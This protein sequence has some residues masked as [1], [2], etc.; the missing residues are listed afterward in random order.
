MKTVVNLETK[1]VRIIIAKFFGIPVESV[2]PN[3]YSFS[4]EGLSAEAIAERIGIAD[5]NNE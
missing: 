3:R 1:D 5:D 4:I 2:I